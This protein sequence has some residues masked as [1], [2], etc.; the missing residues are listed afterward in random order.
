MANEPGKRMDR[1]LS[2]MATQNLSASGNAVLS[3]SFEDPLG[4]HRSWLGGLIRRRVGCPEAVE[5][6]LQEVALAATKSGESRGRFWLCRVALTQSAFWLRNQLRRDRR[7][8][9]PELKS[10]VQEKACADPLM[11]LLALETQETVRR[12]WDHLDQEHKDILRMRIVEGLSYREIAQQL[13]T[14]ERSVEYRLENARR[15]FRAR[16]VEAGLEEPS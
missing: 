9:S 16:L 3:G 12:V 8:Q 4:D 6:V 5:D 1:Q 7:H 10:R 2:I 14:T 15:H 13:G 11:G